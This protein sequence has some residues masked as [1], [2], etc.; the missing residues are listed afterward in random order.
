MDSNQV[1]N[2]TE[3]V[4]LCNKL[5]SQLSQD[6]E[7]AQECFHGEI[8]KSYQEATDK[9]KEKTTEILNRLHSIQSMQQ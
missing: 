5:L 8:L 1:Q 3:A 4:R 7:S 6:R 2:Y 9:A